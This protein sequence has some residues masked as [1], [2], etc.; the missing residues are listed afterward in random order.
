MEVKDSLH[1][2]VKMKSS[3]MFVCLGVL[4]CFILLFGSENCLSQKNMLLWLKAGTE[5]KDGKNT[6]TVRFKVF[7]GGEGGG[8]WIFSF[9]CTLYSV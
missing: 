8:E 5:Q 4:H 9:F 7:W 6:S 2:S 1:S 3:F